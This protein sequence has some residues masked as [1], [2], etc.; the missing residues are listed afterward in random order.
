MSTIHGNDKK[1]FRALMGV[2]GLGA[3]NDNIFKIV[4]SFIVVNAIL[5]EGG[6]IWHLVVINTCFVLPFL[7]FSGSAGTLADKYPKGALIRCYKFVELLIMILAAWF[8]ATR[9]VNALFVV[10]FF[11]GVQSAFFS[12]VKYSYLP[13][14]LT[15]DELSRGN[16][17]LELW[18]F[19]AIILGSAASGYVAVAYEEVAFAPGV[20]LLLLAALGLFAS[21][22]VSKGVAKNP[23]SKVSLNPFVALS[24]LKEIRKHRGLF[25][26]VVALCYFWSVASLYQLNVILYAKQDVGL[27]DVGA[28]VLMLAL[29]VGIGL[30]SV[31]AGKVSEGK[32][33]LGLVPIGA[34]CLSLSSFALRFTSGSFYFSTFCF[35]LVGVSA[36][37]FIVPLASYLQYKSPE[38][39]RGAYLA[40]TNLCT[41]FMMLCSAF[42]LLFLVDGCGL[43]PKDVFLL[44]SFFTLVMAF[45][46]VKTLPEVLIRCINWLIMHTVYRV[47]TIGKLHVPRKGGALLVCNHVAYID[48]QLIMAALDRPVRYLIYKPIYE[49]R[50]INYLAKTMGAIPVQAGG[51]KEANKR[52]LKAASDAIKKGEVVC[53]FAEGGITRSG[54]L[55]SFKKGLENIME[56]LEEPIVPVAMR[57]LW[58][59]IFSYEGGKFIWKWPR[60]FPYP[61]EIEF[62]P[63]MPSSSKASDVQEEV[64][65]MLV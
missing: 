33:E 7:L 48:A 8:F 46:I 38:E 47:K 36:G 18:T 45:Y 56:G 49:A 2:Q 54:E 41:F 12:P 60:K 57:E 35:F 6:G 50:G 42:L 4:L 5:K 1:S 58:G 28:S 9:N 25:L 11:M 55:N 14:I 64:S 26:T 23:Q 21:M 63:P 62:G 30:G 16:G 20:I 53:I 51:D 61:V 15:V 27:D 59:S 32:V 44:M 43:R 3:C 19:V 37:F 24:S 39:K 13:E 52:S 65:K 22:F 17:Y 40:A 31:F 29:G 34:V 10:L